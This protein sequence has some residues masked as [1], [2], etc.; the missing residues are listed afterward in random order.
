MCKARRR[1]V[2]VCYTAAARIAAIGPICAIFFSA[3]QAQAF[4]LDAGTQPS[5][6]F[7][8]QTGLLDMPDARFQR[9]GELA[10]SASS[11]P[12]EDRY[13]LDFQALPWLE[14]DF[15]YTKIAGRFEGYDRSL[16]FKI[17]LSQEGKYLPQLAIG[18][19]DVLGTGLFGAEYL[20]ASKQIG[21]FDLTGGLGWGRLGEVA[22][23]RNPLS[24]FGASFLV[25]SDNVGQG[26]TISGSSLF[27][28]PTVGFFGGIAWQTPIEGLKL[29]AELSGDRYQQEQALHS[30]DIKSQIN[31]GLS[32]EPWQG[33]Q[34]GGG[35]LYGSIFG[36]RMT[37][38]TNPFDLPP[39][40][41]LGTQPVELKE[42]TPEARSQAVLDLLQNTTHFYD[43]WPGADRPR[44]APSNVTASRES[45][46]PAAVDA[47]FD[48]ASFRELRV[49]NVETYGNSLIIEL[50]APKQNLSCA[51]LSDLADAAFRSGFSEI[52]LSSS[53]NLQNVEICPAK[54]A[55]DLQASFHAPG[56][57]SLSPDE[58]HSLFAE[59]SDT[60]S[61]S[62]TPTDREPDSGTLVSAPQ[63]L[64]AVRTKII[65]DASAQGLFVDG[66]TVTTDQIEVALGN[67]TYRTETEA[68]GRFVRVLMAD[69]PD[70]VEQ[71]RIVLMSA[72]TPTIAVT[73]HRSDLERN[74]NLAASAKELLPTTDISPVANDD[75]SISQDSNLKFPTFGFSLLPGY[76]QSLFDPTKPYQF[77]IYAS[78]NGIVALTR[79]LAIQGSFEFNIYN[80]FTSSRPSNSVLPHVRSDFELYQLHGE[81]GIADLNATFS[82]KLSPEVYL[83]AR[84]GYLE[85]M[86]AG[87]GGEM[88]WRP[89]HKRWS[90]GG[91]LYA[92]QQRDFDRLF[93]FR[94]YRVVTG[95]LSFY[96][97]SPFEN[98]DFSVHVGRYLA[99]D[100]G[101]TFQI[102]RRFDS[103]ITVGAYATFTNVPFSQFGEGSFD[104]GI[105]IHIPVDFLAPVNSQDNVNLDFSP[106]T[107]DGGQRLAGEETL[108]DA[109]ETSGEGDLLKTW[110]EV[111]HP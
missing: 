56:T 76:Q 63:G 11:S 48:D 101:A 65:G 30:V 110:N 17:R 93:G 9:D 27:H 34:I 20:V 2:A 41:R 78:A 96:Y 67:P 28:G 88:Y 104:K 61:G 10:F 82:T 37:L 6:N 51:S 50:K 32:Y 52:A 23:F 35:Y 55:R 98:L 109:T 85:S 64:E 25:R 91:A 95:H 83:Y 59:V 75:A 47:L 70:S 92:V 3:A 33:I 90:I 5:Y 13:S 7:Y 36:V 12:T 87:V 58:N 103:G 15:R 22:T 77:G 94:D 102:L 107:R 68:I 42:R 71:F 4:T 72:F 69:A 79:S 81:N 57:S 43:N 111:V 73:L 74:I 86:F 40:E 60:S 8:G 19:Q 53:S 97:D 100:Y 39:N 108:Y 45:G 38:H 29:I 84:A 105:I 99:G 80:T 66:I 89:T 18:V 24:I 62:G 46:A 54:P 14:T 26:G 44:V 1:R 31:L 106:L 49:K 16:G 21:D